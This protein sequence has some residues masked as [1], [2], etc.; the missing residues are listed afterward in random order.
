MLFRHNLKIL[1]NV[2]KSLVFRIGDHVSQILLDIELVLQIEL[3]ALDHVASRL[4]L[5]IDDEFGLIF[6]F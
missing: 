2:G 3:L 1:L 4:F 5:N 6:L